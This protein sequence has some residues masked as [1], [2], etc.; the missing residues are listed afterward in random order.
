LDGGLDRSDGYIAAGFRVAAG[1]DAAGSESLREDG[2]GAL[3]F[4]LEN[5]LGA[6]KSECQ[7]RDVRVASNRVT[8]RLWLISR[9]CSAQALLRPHNNGL[10]HS[11]KGVVD[12]FHT[13][14]DT[15]QILAKVGCPI[16]GDIRSA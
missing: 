9:D 11:K 10:L 16:A 4:A 3:G 14:Y 7:N 5:A 15:I 13:E 12:E 6:D 1:H 2:R 8:A